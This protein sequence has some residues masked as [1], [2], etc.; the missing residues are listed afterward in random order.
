[1]TF[2]VSSCI[3]FQIFRPGPRSPRPLA[4]E[5]EGSL[6]SPPKN[7]TPPSVLWALG[8]GLKG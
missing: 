4:G 6:F 5:E 2:E 7:H 1:V 8:F 3:K